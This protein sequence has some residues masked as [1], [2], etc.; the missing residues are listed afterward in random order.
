VL[1]SGFSTS[2][3]QFAEDQG[4]RLLEFSKAISESN[5]EVA[6]FPETAITGFYPEREELYFERNVPEGPF[7]RFSQL[8][9]AAG[10]SIVAGIAEVRNGFHF[11]SAVVF[12]PSGEC[13]T[14]Y[15][16]RHPFELAGEGA[17]ITPGLQDPVFTV[18]SLIFSLRICYDLRFP[19][20]FH[21]KSDRP[22][23][24]IVLANW[25][26]SR[27]DHWEA[28]LRAR[29]IEGEVNII[30]LNRSGIDDS[31]Q[32]FDGSGLAYNPLGIRYE[33]LSSRPNGQF[34]WDVSPRNEFRTVGRVGTNK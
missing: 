24:V 25:P 23:V 26:T 9:T 32:T 21:H 7:I 11:N 12:E 10:S 17:V 34:T 30:G 27:S 20:D 31:G 6:L 3:E 14:T 28:L 2:P 5:C 19:E 29:A 8:A 33:N 22:D 16:K 15:D 13:V 18:G 1:I 4:A